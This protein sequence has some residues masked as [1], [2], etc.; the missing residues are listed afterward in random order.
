MSARRKP[1]LLVEDDALLALDLADLLTEAGYEVCDPAGSNDVA[2]RVIER[3]RPAFALLDYN[4]GNETSIPTAIE[5]AQ[6]AIPFA[7]VTGRAEAISTNPLAPSA[8]VISK[9]YRP[10]EIL[11]AIAAMDA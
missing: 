1:I 6:R 11:R 7:Y 3:D 8:P 2:R 5:L 9:P 4:L 10:D